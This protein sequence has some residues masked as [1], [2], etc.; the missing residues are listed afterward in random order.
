MTP[1]ASGIVASAM[2]PASAR[3]AI[4]IA[5]TRG[6]RRPESLDPTLILLPPW[7]RARLS[8]PLT[9]GLSGQAAARDRPPAESVTV[10]FAMSSER[11]E[12][13]DDRE[14]RWRK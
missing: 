8:H 7:I 12:R 11:N 5:K 6:S 10:C 14:V 3:P 2:P 1:L 4:A 13:K 9:G